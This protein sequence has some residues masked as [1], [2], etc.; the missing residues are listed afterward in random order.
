MKDHIINST[1][2]YAVFHGPKVD[3]EILKKKY[4]LKI[5][6]QITLMNPVFH[7]NIE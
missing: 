4:N 2:Q 5:L 1:Q 6:S 7:R 3:F